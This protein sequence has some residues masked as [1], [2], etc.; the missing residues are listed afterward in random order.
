MSLLSR[1]SRRT[2]DAVVLEHDAFT[3]HFSDVSSQLTMSVQRGKAEP[4]IRRLSRTHEIVYSLNSCRRRR[5][6][7]NPRGTERTAV[8]PSA[9]MHSNNRLPFSPV[10]Q[11]P[12]SNAG[13]RR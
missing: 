10:L 8:V 3:W 4:K 5:E 12:H 13:A 6:M 2:C 7:P 1:L 11:H 9:S